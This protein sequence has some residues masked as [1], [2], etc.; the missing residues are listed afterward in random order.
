MQLP[1]MLEEPALRPTDRLLLGPSAHHLVDFAMPRIVAAVAEHMPDGST[2]MGGFE[3]LHAPKDGDIWHMVQSYIKPMGATTMCPRDGMRLLRHA[4]Q[5]RGGR[6][7]HRAV[8][9]RLDISLPT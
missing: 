4:D 8:V 5:N 6:Q 7:S 2:P 1:M 3:G 9:V